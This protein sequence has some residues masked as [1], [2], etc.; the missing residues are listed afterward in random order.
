MN[1]TTD[2]VSRNASGFSSL[3]LSSKVY[4]RMSRQHH[5]GAGMHTDYQ[6]RSAVLNE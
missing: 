1:L 4:R 5:D 3:K 2:D 6:N